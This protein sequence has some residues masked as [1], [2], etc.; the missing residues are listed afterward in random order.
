MS[1]KNNTLPI[2]KLLQNADLISDKQLETALSIQSQYTKM[3]LG[4]ILNLQEAV[5]LQTVD[6]FAD[7][8]QEIK[9]EGQQFPLGYYLKKACL[10]NDKQIEMILAEQKKI[11]AKFGDIA[12]QK[13]WLKQGTLDF[14]L[15]E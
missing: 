3:R 2:G 15:N 8:W 14:F 4:D 12:V 5:K 7:R 6:F 1:I 9:Q 10:L 11:Q 13:G